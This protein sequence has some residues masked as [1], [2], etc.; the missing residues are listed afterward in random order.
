MH[1]EDEL[2]EQIKAARE[3]LMPTKIGSNG[4]IMEWQEEYEE[5]EPGHRH[6]SHLYGL[7]PS[8]Q[9]LM[10][11]TPELATAAR[12][13]LERR[14]SFGGGH[15]GWSR[16]W[17]INHYVKLWDGEAAYENFKQL[18]GKSTLPNLFDNHPPFQIDGNFG[19]TAAIAEMLLQ[20]TSERVV[21]LPAL[22]KEWKEGSVKGLC[23]K[24][25]AEVSL[26]WKDGVLTEACIT[27]KKDLETRVRYRDEI[28]E[29]SLKAGESYQWGIEYD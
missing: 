2:N 26:S 3:K 23:I 21:L 20:S 13:T 12:K 29:I 18:M 5:A 24:G 27:A 6:I 16:A 15:T 14:L 7:H 22:P 9:I 11:K 4:T 25:G 17:I 1:V 10:D 19:G 8:E 28:R